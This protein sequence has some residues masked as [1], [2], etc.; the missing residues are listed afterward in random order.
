MGARV[1]Y[2]PR[3]NGYHFQRGLN[4]AMTADDVRSRLIQAVFDRRPV[5]ASR[6]I[7]GLD[8][9]MVDATAL[10]LAHA[11]IDTCGEIG[12]Y[13]ATEQSAILDR[14]AAAGLTADAVGDR[15]YMSTRPVHLFGVRVAPKDAYRAVTLAAEAHYEPVVPMD[16]ATLQFHCSVESSIALTRN[17]DVTTRLEIS[18]R[19]PANSS[20]MSRVFRP[21]SADYQWVR[22]PKALWPLYRAVRPFR[23]VADRVSGRHQSDY[24]RFFGTPAQLIPMLLDFA[25]VDADDVLY[26][27][28][29]GDGRIVM[30]AART[31]GC[32]GVGV[33]ARPDL[34][35]LA[36]KKA[37]AMSVADRV[38]F[39]AGEA[40]SV[41]LDDATVVF[42]FLPVDVLG[43]VL[44]SIRA[45]VGTDV[46]IVAHEQA[47]LGP[48][49]VSDRAELLL[50]PSALTVAH[51]WRAK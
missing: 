24:G 26:D 20:R 8:E 49:T 10:A 45:R 25:E 14:F 7:I 37:S 27:L 43:S 5:E 34:V 40:R 4:V 28:G 19:E 13:C 15:D 41:A 6:E 48:G 51:L 42:L 18:W 46:R 50:A 9:D 29:C 39:V 44:Q 35:E 36:D 23:L 11:V 21:G 2:D 38:E 16:A 12:R 33:E 32:R 1:G 22:L 3:G 17:D 31:R 47:P 30:E